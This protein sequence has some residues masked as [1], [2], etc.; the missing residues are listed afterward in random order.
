[1]L[2]YPQ[3]GTGALSQFPVRIERRARTVVNAAPDGTAIKLADPAGTVTEWTLNYTGLSDAERFTLEQF[4]ASAQ[5]SL[6]GFTF[7]DPAANLLAWS[8]D[9]SQP[10]WVP[11]PALTVAGGVGDPFGGTAAWSLTNTGAAPQSLTQTLPAPGEYLYCLSVYARALTAGAV[12]MSIGTSQTVHT[13]TEQ[14]ARITLAARGDSSEQE[15]AFGLQVPAGVQVEI[16]GM[17]AEPQ[18]AASEYRVSTTG[19]VYLNARL[20]DDQFTVITTAPGR[21]SCSVRILYVNHL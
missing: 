8:G 21:H 20:R 13:V 7:V 10:V 14:W 6:N 9:P 4:F 19:G 3:L 18:P 11:D 5:G 1:M 15:V 17:Q 2:A 12:T 16:Y